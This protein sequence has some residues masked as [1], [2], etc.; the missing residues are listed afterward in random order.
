MPRLILMAAL[1]LISGCGGQ[2]TKRVVYNPTSGPLGWYHPIHAYCTQARSLRG[3][4]YP[5]RK[6]TSCEVTPMIERKD[7]EL[8][9]TTTG[10]ICCTWHLTQSNTETWCIA[11]ARYHWCNWFQIFTSPK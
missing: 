11:P 3:S 9:P 2:H 4:P 6:P 1:L 8:A 7:G 5:N 10:P